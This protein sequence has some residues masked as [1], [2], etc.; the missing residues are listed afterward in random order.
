MK[1][2]GGIVSKLMT[3]HLKASGAGS[4]DLPYKYMNQDYESLK[5]ECL[6]RGS[7]FE[8]PYFP[9]ITSSLGY[10]KF[11]PESNTIKGVE[12]KRPSEIVDKPQFIV[13]G[14]TRK[15]ICQGQSADC[16]LLCA[17]AC[18]T[19]NEHLLHRV[20]PHGQ[21]FQ[22]D[23][24]GIFHFQIWQYSE[25][26]DVVIDDRL[27][28]KDEKLMF[29]HSAEGSEF[30]SPL[31]EKAYAK[32]NSS[33]EA[34]N[35]GF[36]NEAFVNFSGGL[37]EYY[38]LRNNPPGLDIMREA[39][40]R[41][42]MMSCHITTPAKDP[43]PFE[44]DVKANKLVIL[45]VYAVTGLE[46]VNYKGSKVDL[47]RLRNPWG[48]SEWSG[49]W[50]DNSPE[51][52]ELDPSE[53]NNL[54]LKM[55]DGEF[56]MP[57]TEFERLFTILEICNLTP[58][59]LKNPGLGKW[60]T[61][62]YEGSWRRGSTAGGCKD[63]PETFWMNPKFKI[64]LLKEDDDPNDDKLGCNLL[65]A[66]MQKN[67]R[68]EYKNEVKNYNKGFAIY[69]VPDEGLQSMRKEFFQTHEPC[70]QKYEERYEVS[71]RICLPP[72]EYVI[73]PSTWTPNLTADF[74]LRIF[75]ETQSELIDLDKEVSVDLP[76][77]V[78]LTEEDV[79]EAFKKKFQ[80]T[81]GKATLTEKEVEDAFKKEFQ[82]LAGEVYY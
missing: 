6:K 22:D 54:Q 34:I 67:F 68:R 25:W 75:T 63:N 15:D 73:I 13:E 47:I 71:D 32:L 17:I 36:F 65:V 8:D 2:F 20:V 57:F 56:W 30:W 60:H 61:A 9:A 52:N 26:V 44:E 3:D 11:G 41:G 80:E 43:K 69:K 49:A 4:H 28:V 70:A 18:L 12:W 50:S 24:V 27:P 38:N 74:L 10:N 21:N 14:A 42:S 23:Y 19:M 45:H 39:L 31:L 58:D 16:W 53:R 48:K 59:A 64:T 1:P 40:K 81:S 51:W 33:Y 62:M 29:V 7:L 35:W 37:G 79:K 55:E 78:T 5:Q 66:V 46:Q 77:E 76:D 82:E 72:G